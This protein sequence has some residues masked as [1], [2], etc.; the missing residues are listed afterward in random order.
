MEYKI[1]KKNA[2]ITK[3]FEKGK[4]DSNDWNVISKGLCV[5]N[6]LLDEGLDLQKSTI[7]SGKGDVS[8]TKNN[9]QLYRFIANDILN[10]L[11][12][13]SKRRKETITNIGE[14][15]FFAKATQAAR[16]GVIL[17]TETI[18]ESIGEKRKITKHDTTMSDREVLDVLINYKRQTNRIEWDKLSAYLGL[19]L[20]IAGILGSIVN[21]GTKEQNKNTSKTGQLVSM[22]TIAIGALK[23]FQGNLS[24]E[25]KEILWE[26]EDIEHN[27]K[28][29]LLGSEQISQ[30]VVKDEIKEIER[31]AIE[32][33]KV[34]E[35]IEVGNFKFNALID[36]IVATISGAFIKSRYEIKDNGMIDGKSL[37]SALAELNA[38][39]SVTMEILN[40]IRKLQMTKVEE[41]DLKII[42]EQFNSII[43]QMEEKVYPLNRT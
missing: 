20:G 8:K 12:N 27:L 19:G 15:E 26:L 40:G 25:Q 38:T 29:G 6:A 4:L 1:Q 42:R 28:S 36:V 33:A 35:K 10:T 22:G 32:G 37:A 41:E 9:V 43:K 2:G 31:V 13:I 3:N 17:K 23:L 5:L 24:R 7:L 39:K 18:E 14:L 30:E 21:N 34:S 16:D 11:E